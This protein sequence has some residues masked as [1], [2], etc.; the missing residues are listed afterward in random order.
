MKN[1]IF[2][3]NEFWS[4]CLH[5][6]WFVLFTLLIATNE[7]TILSQ[8]ATCWN[9]YRGNSALQGL[10]SAQIPDNPEIIWNF[11]TDGAIKASPVVCNGIIVIGSTDGNVYGIGMDGSLKWKINTGNGIEAP[12][13]ILNGLAYVG[14][15][16]GE[17]F[18]IELNSG[19]VKWTYKTDGQVMG[20][21]NYFTN[22]ISRILVVGSYDYFLHG[23]DPETGKGLWK[24]EADN[25]INGTPSI[26][27]NMVVFG[28]C[29]G[30]LHMVNASNGKL[31]KKVEVATYVAGSVA[32]AN[33][34]AYLG[35]YDGKFSCLDLKTFNVSWYYEPSEVRQPYIG[36]PSIDKNLVFIGNRDKYVY[37]FEK[38]GGKL[39]WKT[40]TAGRIEAS[41]VAA[42]SRILI[43]NMRG[44]IL[45]LDSSDGKIIWNYE[46]GTPVL[47]TPALIDNKIIVGAE[48]GRI[49]CLGRK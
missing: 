1:I 13:L 24:Y 38:A 40:N 36:S 26:Y 7:S 5:V 11:K 28:G 44:D 41:P 43:S 29:D 9:N 4:G 35:D 27:N 17:I 33:G 2:K 46:L 20:S 39:R 48:D 15:L 47:G 21:V 31:N 30:Y 22:A 37:C 16:A 3:I 49:Y 23:I 45:A 32:I 8:N 14:N 10:S 6:K 19:R 12:A 25:F 42:G 18:A 34:K